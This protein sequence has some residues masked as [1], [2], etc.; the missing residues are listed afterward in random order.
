MS[1]LWQV[2]QGGYS[3]ESCRCVVAHGAVDSE[4]GMAGDVGAGDGGEWQ[5]S[6]TGGGG[7]RWVLS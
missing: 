6:G 2:R 3:T 4:C 1:S 5:L 7:G